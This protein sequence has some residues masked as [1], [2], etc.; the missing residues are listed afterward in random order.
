MK[1]ANLNSKSGLI[2]AIQYFSDQMVCL[3]TVA[4]AKWPNGKKYLRK[5]SQHRH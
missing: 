1:T 2:E 4:K 3:E 5:S